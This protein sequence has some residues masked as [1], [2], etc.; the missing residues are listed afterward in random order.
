MKR[1]RI[2]SKMGMFAVLV[3]A[4]NI[5]TGV[6]TPTFAKAASL[7]PDEEAALIFQREEEKLAHDVYLTMYE[8]WGATIFSNILASEQRHMDTMLKM[9]N[10][11]GVEDPAAGKGTGEFSNAEIKKSYD[12]LIAQ[13]NISLID[14][15]Q[16]G[17]EI[18]KIDISDILDVLAGTQKRDLT[19]AYTNLL[20]GSYNH[21]QAFQDASAAQGQ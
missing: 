2:I 11:Y 20:D 19:T 21:L 6:G 12:D 7:T 9:L 15:L 18:E 17:V 4:I 1:K 3:W 8:K 13:G 10:K 14:A 5:I 16:V